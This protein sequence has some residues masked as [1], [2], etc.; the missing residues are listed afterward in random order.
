MYKRQDHYDGGYSLITVKDDARYLVVPEN[1]SVPDGLDADIVVLQQ[2]LDSIYPVSYT[3]LESNTMTCY[4]V[5]S[6]FL[7]KGNLQFHQFFANRQLLFIH[8]ADSKPWESLISVSYTHLDVYKRQVQCDIMK[9]V[10][11]T[12]DERK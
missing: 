3:H 7:K 1:A 11:K 8:I 12:M 10:E 5:H 2:P 9:S 4:I 6:K